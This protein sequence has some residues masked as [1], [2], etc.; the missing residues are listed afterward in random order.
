MRCSEPQPWR[1]VSMPRLRAYPAQSRHVLHH[2]A[3]H[4]PRLRLAPPCSRARLRAAVAELG[5]VRRF[6]AHPVNESQSSRSQAWSP[7]RRDSVR[8]LLSSARGALHSQRHRRVHRM[9][10]ASTLQARDRGTAFRG[11][12]TASMARLASVCCRPSLRCSLGS[13]TRQLS[14]SLARPVIASPSLFCFGAT[15]P[16][17]RCYLPPFTHA[18]SMNPNRTETPNHALQ[19][20]APA[21]TLAA[22]AAALPPTMQPARQPPPS[23]SLGSLGKVLHRR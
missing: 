5:V 18:V 21:V 20:T 16:I 13:S 4:I 19:R 7:S 1:S 23:L 12:A 2:Q 6:L 15:Y 9:E 11:D 17:C 8:P 14:Q 3:R 22:S 10:A